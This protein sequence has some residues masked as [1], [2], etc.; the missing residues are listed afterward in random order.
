MA[1]GGGGQRVIILFLWWCVK[2]RVKDHCF[3][4]GL[5]HLSGPPCTLLILE[6]ENSSRED[7]G[8]AE[9]TEV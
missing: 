5:A 3:E 2:V 8:V 4:R 7:K 1:P 9:V 6:V